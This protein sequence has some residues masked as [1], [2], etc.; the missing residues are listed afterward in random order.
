MKKFLSGI[1]ISTFFTTLF[2]G[3]AFA[4]GIK[5]IDGPLGRVITPT[6]FEGKKDIAPI[7]GTAINLVLSL[8]GLIF[9]ILMVY[10]GI[11]WMTARGEESQVEKAQRI[12]K[13]SMIGLFVVVSA[14]AITFLV[15]SRFK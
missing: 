3:T 6:G 2:F 1:I 15:M 13:A 4:Q 14:Y 10:A 8:V 11:L 7:V 9:L 5:S 12:I